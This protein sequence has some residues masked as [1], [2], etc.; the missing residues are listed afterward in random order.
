M[1]EHTLF[2]AACLSAASELPAELASP[3]GGLTSANR[4]VLGGGSAGDMQRCLDVTQATAHA[5][6]PR[7]RIQRTASALAA[8][9]PLDLLITSGNNQWSVSR[10]AGIW[11]Y[12]CTCTVSFLGPDHHDLTA[13]GQLTLPTPEG[14]RRVLADG[15]PLVSA[16]GAGAWR[17]GQRQGRGHPLTRS[18]LTSAVGLCAWRHE[19]N[20]AN[21][22]SRIAALVDLS[23]KR[24][25]GGPVRGCV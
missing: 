19:K 25:D 18:V 9:Y 21:W 14:L 2:R 7:A 24:A 10:R 15:C 12:A 13:G 23:I 17:A 1:N 20:P 5:L 8:G 4:G 22:S 6:A 16:Y 11:P 3:L